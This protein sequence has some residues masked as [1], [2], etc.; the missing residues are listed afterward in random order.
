VE[1][2]PAPYEIIGLIVLGLI[3]LVPILI[4]IPPNNAYDSFIGALEYLVT[5]LIYVLGEIWGLL[6][7]RRQKHRLA[8]LA[9]IFVSITFLLSF[10]ALL[11]LLKG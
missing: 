10:G 4:T 8:L 5:G 3:A 11:S 2:K 7:W 6:Y 1:T 9:F